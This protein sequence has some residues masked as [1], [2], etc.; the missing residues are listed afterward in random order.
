MSLKDEQ[1]R[2][3][4]KYLYKYYYENSKNR[5][6]DAIDIGKKYKREDGIVYL[7]F[8]R[9]QPLPNVPFYDWKLNDDSSG[10]ED[11]FCDWEVVKRPMNPNKISKDIKRETNLGLLMPCVRLLFRTSIFQIPNVQKI[12]N[13]KYK[14]FS[15]QNHTIWK[16]LRILVSI[17]L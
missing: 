11:S 10:S 2:A 8:N 3:L 6:L 4:D 15:R 17:L 1:L 7:Y 16:I 14:N 9:A 13:C 12:L 5:R